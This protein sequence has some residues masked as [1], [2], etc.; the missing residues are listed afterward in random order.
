MFAVIP[1]RS[2]WYCLLLLVSVGVWKHINHLW[3]LGRR[4]E[5]ERFQ[6]GGGEGVKSLFG[7]PWLPAG[8]DGDTT[9]FSLALQYYFSP[10]YPSHGN[11]GRRTGGFNFPWLRHLSICAA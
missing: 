4:K 2:L 9:C 7:W 1:Y 10:P 11:Q 8:S 3:L 6:G 5:G